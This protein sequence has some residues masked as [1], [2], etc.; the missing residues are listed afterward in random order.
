MDNVI[1][2]LLVY[3]YNMIFLKDDN[4]PD[5]FM[6]AFK[7]FI[8]RQYVYRSRVITLNTEQAIKYLN[9]NNTKK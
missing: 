9:K 3:Y 7:R 8:T 2:T 4:E 1:K 6:I 5:G